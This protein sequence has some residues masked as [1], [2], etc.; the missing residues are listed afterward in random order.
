VAEDPHDRLG[1]GALLGELGAEGV[2]EPVGVDGGLALGVEEPE[3][4]ADAGQGRGEEVVGRGQPAVVEEQ[5]ADR[6]TEVAVVEASV[7][8]GLAEPG[9]RSVTSPPT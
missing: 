1:A 6:D 7:G 5:V 9:P 2:A 3:A 8:L 4:I